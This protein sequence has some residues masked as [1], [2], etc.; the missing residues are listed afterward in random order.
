MP[1][2]PSGRDPDEP[3]G[4]SRR[5]VLRSTAVLGGTSVIGGLAA[6]G[7]GPGRRADPAASA[8]PTP[9]ASAS[10]TATVP[11]D[12][13]AESSAAAHGQ[14]ALIAASEVP[15]GGGVVLADQKVVVTQP[16]AGQFRAFSAICTHQGCV[17]AEVSSAAIVCYCHGSAFSID[18]GSVTNPPA[19]KALPPVAVTVRDGNVVRS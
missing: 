18:D 7:S 6:C 19:K 10:A 14:P 9:V 11:P 1:C 15:Q 5:A 3:A 13:A 4:L 8:A 2:T 17:V 16:T 12:P